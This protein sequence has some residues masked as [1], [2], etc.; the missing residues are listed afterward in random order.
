MTLVL[1]NH[2]NWLLWLGVQ[3]GHV[4]VAARRAQEVGQKARQGWACCGSRGCAPIIVLGMYVNAAPRPPN[5]PPLQRHAD[6]QSR[7]DPT[8]CP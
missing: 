8:E 3:P 4:T 2:V 1:G 7:Q 5:Y 6:S